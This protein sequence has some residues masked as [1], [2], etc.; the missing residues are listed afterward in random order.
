MLIATLAFAL[1]VFVGTGTYIRYTY[2]CYFLF[3]IA[4]AI[5]LHGLPSALLRA[6]LWLTAIV[7]LAMNVLYLPAAYRPNAEFPLAT[8]VDANARADF[9]RRWAWPRLAVPLLNAFPNDRAA[10]FIGRP[11]YYAEF[12]RTVYGDSSYT[13]RFYQRT[14]TLKSREDLVRT[15]AELDLGYIVVEDAMLRAY[16][17][18]VESVAALR[19]RIASASVYEVD[20][21]VQFPIELIERRAVAPGAWIEIAGATL[22][23][24]VAVVNQEVAWYQSVPVRGGV[25]HRIAVT[26]RCHG[27]VRGDIRLQVIWHDAQARTKVSHRSA[28]CTDVWREETAIFA[29]PTDA[30]RAVVFAIGHG[31]NDVAIRE[32]SFRS[33]WDLPL[34]LPHYVKAEPIGR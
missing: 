16:R 21:Q 12:R 27:G 28:P 24:G 30:V 8:I 23:D 20:P 25:E 33:R 14:G 19:Y 5:A 34:P 13:P 29:A 18:L 2:P 22:R 32:V 6:S 26:A 31:A 17:P 15:V 11:P 1:V 10:L 3:A 9:L 7:S 4:A